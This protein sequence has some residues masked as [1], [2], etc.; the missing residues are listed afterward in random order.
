MAFNPINWLLGLFSLDIG[1]D[2]GTANTL[3]YVRGKGIV[4]NE[5]SWVA[6]DKRSRA[7][8]AIGLEA[9]EMAGRTSGSLMV[10]RPIRDGVISEFEIT[11]AMLEYFIGKVHE[12]TIV[13][14]PRPRVVIGIPSG[15]TQVE[16]RAVYDAS[17]S[18]GARDTYLIEEPIAAALGAGLPVNEVRG[19][20]VVDIGGGTTEVAVISMGR[21]VVSR[22]LR[23]A[24][25]EMDQDIV[26]YIRNKYNLLVG[27][28]IAEHIKWNIGSAFQLPVEKTTEV[29][30]RNLVTGL[31][32]SVIVSSVEMREA[33]T[34]SI[35]VIVDTVKDTLDEAP[36]E[37]IADLMEMGICLAGGGALLQGLA[38]RL[39]EE[40]NLRVWVA[41]DPLTCV[42]RGTGI[43]LDDFQ[44]SSRFLVGLER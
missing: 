23:V 17:M 36:P 34:G 21:V 1:I 20:M 9:K 44:N 35:Q 24:G 30:G 38:E 13:P 27:E 37:I 6:I 33:L 11:E 2:L 15:V 26:Q 14:L 12:Q 3:V 25:D 4:I 18:A 5:P 28:R 40:L 7:P 43:I 32:E 16:K 31:P 42:V 8:L 10:V 41:E 19:T 39:A 29:R 22:S